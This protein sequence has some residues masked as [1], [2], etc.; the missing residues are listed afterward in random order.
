MKS[1]KKIIPIIL[2]ISILFSLSVS[3]FAAYSDWETKHVKNQVAVSIYKSDFTSKMKAFFATDKRYG[4]LNLTS[5]EAKYTSEYVGV[6]GDRHTAVY[7]QGLF[8]T[9]SYGYI[10]N[11]RARETDYESLGSFC[12]VLTNE[13]LTTNMRLCSL[14]YNGESF[15]G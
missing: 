15:Q 4:K 9:S 5:L 6:L 3:A 10:L 8:H 14:H 11:D 2:S 12:A 1:L 13:G 7:W